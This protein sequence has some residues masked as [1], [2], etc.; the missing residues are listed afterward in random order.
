[1]LVYRVTNTVNGKVYIGK[2]SHSTPDL[3]WRLHK[4]AAKRGSPYYF[5]RAIRKYG[6]DA[7]TEVIH[8]AKT[9]EE[10]SAME[11]F[12]IVLHQSHVPVNGYN[13]MTLGG[14]GR[15]GPMPGEWK[16]WKSGHS[17]KFWSDPEYRAKQSLA[18]KNWWTQER[19]SDNATQ[20][21]KGRC[22]RGERWEYA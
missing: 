5:H 3:R 11:T 1:M 13:N 10:L 21:R 7:F 9:P 15:L 4:S 16:K 14:E 2:W 19:R 18:H 6:L 22:F 8:R 12:F 20:L 17:K